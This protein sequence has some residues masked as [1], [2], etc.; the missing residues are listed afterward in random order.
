MGRSSFRFRLILVLLIA[1]IVPISASMVVTNVYT[2]QSVRQ[3]AIR[4]ST[5]LL[6]QGRLN[7]INYMDSL[8]Q[9]SFSIYSDSSFI[10][11]TTLG[12]TGYQS[13][14][15]IYRLMQTISLNRDVSQVYMNIFE[16]GPGEARSFLVRN[17][18]RYPYSDI[19][20]QLK[21]PYLPESFDAKVE[22]AHMSHTYGIPMSFYYAP[23]PV[24]S[25][26]RAIFRIPSMKQIGTFSIDVRLTGLAELM[27]RL[28]TEQEDV[29]LLD[30]GGT[31]I[32]SSEAGWT[33]GESRQGEEWV[34]RMLAQP[35]ASGH[36]EAG[37]SIHMYEKVETPYLTWY[38]VKR[39]PY[40]QLYQGARELLRIQFVILAVLMAVVA[41]LTLWISVRFTRPI[42]E[43][44][45]YMNRIRSGQLDVDIQ[46]SSQ[47]EIGILAR[48]FRDM[49]GTINHLITQEYKLKLANR[50]NQLKALQA[51]IHPHFLYNSLQSIG[52]LALQ[53]GV[54]KVYKLLSALAKMMRY[55]MSTGETVVP[56]RRELEHVKAYLQLQTQ[57]FENEL[58]VRYDMD[59]A[60]VDILLP[61]MTLQPLVENYFKHGFDPRHQTGELTLS[62][63]IDAEAS[64][65]LLTLVIEDNGR[66]MPAEEIDRLNRLLSESS[67][68]AAG[69]AGAKDEAIG[70]L[71]VKTRLELFISERASLRLEPRQPA[72]L[73][74]VIVIPAES[75]QREEA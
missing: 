57:R 49:M 30:A 43:L 51:Q 5:R 39:I 48:H 22:P 74:V 25:I 20:Y 4:E 50:T 15:E 44:I 29:Y 65:P 42:K 71:N 69:E 33:P 56:L 17:M 18:R 52:T 19:S 41:L 8:N 3:N 64:P 24:I 47:D 11:L 67:A 68:S 13:E 66:G 31:V 45:G 35:E 55:S 27:N 75:P 73:R 62:S 26:H 16:R 6:E 59:E 21:P 37:Q 34:G 32:Y 9:L 38:M 58:N 60:S 1:T 10:R 72:G 23:E 12:F 40:D 63:R 7:L 2:K 46:V 14:P 54:P 36:L 70:L 53:S 28:R 61:K